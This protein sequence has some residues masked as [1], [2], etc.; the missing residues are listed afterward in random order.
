M[1]IQG[2]RK[3]GKDFQSIAEIIGTKTEQQVN[4]FFINSRKKFDL[5]DILKEFE[6]KQLQEQK[7]QQQKLNEAQ[8]KS[9][10]S[11]SSNIANS[12]NE[13][14]TNLKKLVSDDEI[15]EVSKNLL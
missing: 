1:A 13:V 2:I 8:Q 4:Q 6:A 10:S 3:Y 9:S 11:N 12:K 5:D 14:K 7:Q 15:M